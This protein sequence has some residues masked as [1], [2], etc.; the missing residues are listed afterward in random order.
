MAAWGRSSTYPA[1]KPPI[2]W[3]ARQLHPPIAMWIWDALGF[4]FEVFVLGAFVF[5]VPGYFLLE[6]L[7]YAWRGPSEQLKSV[8]TSILDEPASP[9]LQPPA[10]A[11]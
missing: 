3:L 8:G 6:V 4:A 2:K 5:W 7:R 11:A 1:P 10:R 9:G